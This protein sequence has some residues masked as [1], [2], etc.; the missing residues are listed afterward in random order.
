VPYSRTPMRRLVNGIER[1]RIR[2]GLAP[3][4]RYLL[5]VGGRRSGRPTSTPVGLVEYGPDRWL[6]APYGEVNWVRNARAAKS[7][8]LERGGRGEDFAITEVSPAEAAPVL[9]AYVDSLEP[10]TRPFFDAVPQSP[11]GAFAAEAAKHLVFRLSSL[12][13]EKGQ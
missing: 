2:L 3:G 11:D 1:A 13:H 8:R 12:S 9:K 10:I 6:V 4:H 5:T 7:V